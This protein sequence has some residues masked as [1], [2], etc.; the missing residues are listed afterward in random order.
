MSLDDE[1]CFTS[2]TTS[3]GGGGGVMFAPSSFV[4]RKQPLHARLQSGM[5]LQMCYVNDAAAELEGCAS[6]DDSTLSRSQPDVIPE[7]NL[8]EVR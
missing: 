7:H 5:N 1:S 6:D 4:Q 8:H 3:M 2:S